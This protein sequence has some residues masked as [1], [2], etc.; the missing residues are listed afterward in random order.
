MESP[1]LF[2]CD[3]FTVKR[4]KGPNAEAELPE[5]P[6]IDSLWLSI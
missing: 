2:G 1:G 4:S 3:F 5:F 6:N